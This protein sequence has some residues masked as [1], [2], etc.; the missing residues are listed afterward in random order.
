MYKKC[1]I[2]CCLLSISICLFAQPLSPTW[3]KRYGGFGIE[4]GYS[5][6]MTMDGGCVIVGSKGGLEN[7]YILKVDCNGDSLWSKK[8]GGDSMDYAY[9]VVNMENDGYAIAGGNSSIIGK[10]MEMY[11]IRTDR[12]G[13]TLWTRTYGGDSDDYARSIK[14]TPDSGFVLAGYTY[15]FGDSGDMY[16]VRTDKNGD[17]LWTKTYGGPGGDACKAIEITADSGYILFGST[18]SSR[19]NVDVYLVRTDKNGDTLWTKTFGTS[20]NDVIYSGQKTIDGGFVLAG[21]LDTIYNDIYVARV[22]A[23]GDTLWTRRYGGPGR[24]EAYAIRPTP[25]SGFILCGLKNYSDTK[26][27]DGYLLKI[28]AKGDTLWSKLFGGPGYERFFDV[29]VTPDGGFILVGDVADSGFTNSDMY[30]VRTDA[31]GNVVA[32]T[33]IPAF[34]LSSPSLRVCN[35]YGMSRMAIRYS[36]PKRGQIEID[37]FDIQGK[38]IGSPVHAYQEKGSYSIVWDAAQVLGRELPSGIC[39]IRLRTNNAVVTQKIAI[40]R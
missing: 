28:N 25:D 31:E 11:L 1:I 9:S 37:V 8:Y 40:M 35:E 36:L 23:S 21:L 32:E 24:E 15:S 7:A 33:V 14:E 5:L 38:R 4:R 3:I 17:T 29:Q 34:S 30:I 10:G 6:Q 20:Y 19:W 27:D 22:T 2:I 26:R 12:N 16:L 39:F 13:D 18:F